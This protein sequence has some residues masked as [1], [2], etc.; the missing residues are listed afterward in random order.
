MR[1]LIIVRT[2]FF[3][4]VGAPQAYTCLCISLVTFTLRRWRTECAA[5][6]SREALPGETIH[7]FACSYN[8]SVYGPIPELVVEAYIG[9]YLYTDTDD[10]PL[11]AATAFSTVY[12]FHLIAFLLIFKISPLTIFC[13]ISDS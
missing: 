10:Y 7:V 12:C 9:V 13:F 11:L 3:Y 8:V 5:S 1:Y 4:S 6:N 2:P